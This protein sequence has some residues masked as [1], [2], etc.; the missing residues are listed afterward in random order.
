M[1]YKMNPNTGMMEPYMKQAVISDD[2][3]VVLRRDIGDFNHDDLD[4]WNFEVQT[5]GGNTKYDLHLYVGDDGDLLP[6]TD[7][8]IRIP[9]NS[10]FN[11]KK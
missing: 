9:K 4:H 1:E 5:I 2:Y 3:K 7:D 8:N 11:K 10:P 6:F